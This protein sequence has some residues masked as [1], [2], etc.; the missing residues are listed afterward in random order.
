MLA[1]RHGQRETARFRL[2]VR[3]KGALDSRGRAALPLA[4]RGEE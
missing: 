4:V 2:V 1:E 3:G